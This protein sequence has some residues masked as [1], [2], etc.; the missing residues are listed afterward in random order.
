[1]K[2]TE[3]MIGFWVYSIIKKDNWKLQPSDFA[4]L[5]EYMNVADSLPIEPIPITPEILKKN[6]FRDCGDAG[7]QRLPDDIAPKHLTIYDNGMFSDGVPFRDKNISLIHNINHV[8][9]LQLALHLSGLD[10]LA[11]NF[12][13]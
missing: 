11:D 12:A 10:E 8:H 9:T 1:M 3:L 6:G 4:R 2:I 13:V 7:F 5:Y